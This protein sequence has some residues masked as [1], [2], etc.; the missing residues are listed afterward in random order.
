MQF[1][2]RGKILSVT[3]LPEENAEAFEAEALETS[4]LVGHP[5]RKI[6]FPKDAIVG[7]IMRNGKVIIPDGSTIIEPGD[8]VIIF[9]LSSATSKVEKALT[10]KLEY[11]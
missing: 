10:V 11:W 1:I 5:L 6:N 9:A 4:D 3:Y 8:R 2:R 7:A